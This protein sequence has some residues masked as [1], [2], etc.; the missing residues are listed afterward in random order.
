MQNDKNKLDNLLQEIE[1]YFD[2]SLTEEEESVLRN[3]LI[4]TSLT[5]PAIDEA[6][7]IM[8]FRTIKPLMPEF[9]SLTQSRLKNIKLNLG[10]IAGIAAV[11]GVLI[12]TGYSLVNKYS[13]DVDSTC[14]AYINGKRVTDEEIVMELLAQNLNELEKG[15]NDARSDLLEEL[16]ILSP[17]VEQCTAEPTTL[18]IHP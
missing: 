16:D 18:D 11:I 2:C 9:K 1:K 12:I 4:N 3:E 13:S 10:Y 7:A 8:G 17:A 14:L 15:A 5:H 6:K